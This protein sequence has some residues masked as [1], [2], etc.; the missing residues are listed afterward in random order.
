MIADALTAAGPGAIKPVLAALLLP[1]VPFIVMALAGAGV[2]RARPRV[3]RWL[4]SIAC[5][6][7]WLSCC[8]GV[9]HWV[10]T[11][12]LAEPPALTAAQR[13]VLKARAAAGETMAIVVLGGGMDRE[14]PEYD[15]R[16]DLA[17]APLARLRYAAWL[18]RQTGIPLAASGGRGWGSSDPAVTAEATR[19]AQIAQAEFGTPP[20]WIEATSRDT[21]ENAI[22]TLAL[23]RAAGI[24]EIVVVTTGW[25]MPRAM[26]EFRAAAAA[27]AA[28]GTIVVTPAPMGQAYPADTRVMRWMPSGS[29][30]LR[31]HQVLHEV[32]AGI[33]DHR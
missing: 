23:L 17:N 3:A 11:T 14:A 29:G 27:G 24:H 10:E 9:V 20:R 15:G 25:H 19:T 7:I 4:V 16:D 18:S 13:A 8:T 28:S 2:T 6:G 30:L 12:W 21:H 26:R 22:D 32:I 5:V 1:P 33:G 31:M